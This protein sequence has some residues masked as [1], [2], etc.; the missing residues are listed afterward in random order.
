[1]ELHCYFLDP[2]FLEDLRGN[3]FCQFLQSFP[4]LFGKETNLS[5]HAF[6]IYRV[7]NFICRPRPRPRPFKPDSD[8]NPLE[9]PTLF[10]KNPN[11]RPELQR[12]DGKKS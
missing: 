6:V 2:L 9:G 5:V 11:T 8:K 7:S 1:M 12:M 3:V 4:L 10:L